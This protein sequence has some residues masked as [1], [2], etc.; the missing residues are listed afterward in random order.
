MMVKKKCEGDEFDGGEG[1][2]LRKREGSMMMK[3]NHI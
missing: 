1:E 3:G 2:G